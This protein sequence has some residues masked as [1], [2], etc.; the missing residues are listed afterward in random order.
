MCPLLSSW[1]SPAMKGNGPFLFPH[2]LS[3]GMTQENTDSSSQSPSTVQAKYTFHIELYLFTKKYQRFKS[4]PWCIQSIYPYKQNRAPEFQKGYL[5]ITPFKGLC[6]HR[7]WDA[8][9][10]HFCTHHSGHPP[11]D[12]RRC[13]FSASASGTGAG[14]RLAPEAAQRS[15]TAWLGSPPL[16]CTPSGWGWGA[17]AV[18]TSPLW[19]DVE[20]EQWQRWE[21][22][23]RKS[24]FLVNVSFRPGFM[25]VYPRCLSAMTAGFHGPLP[26]MQVRLDSGFLSA[27]L[28]FNIGIPWMSINDAI[29]L[30]LCWRQFCWIFLK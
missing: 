24:L 27:L 8:S 20:Q 25:D 19:Q 15:G 10:S 2:R 26:Q 21:K 6:P 1:P 5:K 16:P 9:S 28:F 18:H 23:S 11:P 30:S 7:G 22:L 29:K 13:P 12:W 14:C 3:Q 4:Y 17:V